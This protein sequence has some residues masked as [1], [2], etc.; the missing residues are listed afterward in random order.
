MAASPP[1]LACGTGSAR[2]GSDALHRA[3]QSLG[4]WLQRELQLAATGRAPE[5]GNFLLAEGDRGADRTLAVPLKHHPP[6]FLAGIPAASARNQL[7]ASCWPRLRYTPT[8]PTRRIPQTE[9][10][11]TLGSPLR[12]SQTTR[13]KNSRGGVNNYN[14]LGDTNPFDR[15]Q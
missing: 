8:R 7:A 6:A 4:E 11:S 12:G 10:L 2:S 15:V 9:Y 1:P 14:Y 5:R 3:R 13:R